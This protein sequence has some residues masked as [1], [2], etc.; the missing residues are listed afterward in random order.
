LN[1]AIESDV[2]I[3]AKSISKI[4]KSLLPVICFRDG[5]PPLP[6]ASTNALQGLELGRFFNGSF[7]RAQDSEIAQQCYPMQKNITLRLTN[8]QI[9]PGAWY[10]GLFNGIGATRTQGKMIVRS[11]A[12]SFSA[13]ISVEGCKTATMW[14]PFCN[15]TIYPLSCSRFDNQTASVI[16]CADSFPSSCLTGAETKTYALDVDGIAEQL[17]IMASNVKVDSNE[18]YLMCYARFEAFAS[19]TLHDYA[20]DIHKVPLIVNKPKAGRWYIVISLSGRENRFAQGTNSS[21]RVCFS[22]NVKVLGCPVGKAGPNCGQ[23]IYILQ[24]VMRRGWLTPFQSYYFPVNDASLSGSSTNFPLE[25]IV[26]NFSSIPELDTSTWTYFLMNIPQG[27]SGGHI[28]FRL[29]SDSTIQ[30]EVYLR[31]GGLP[32]IDD[33]DYYY[34]NR[35]SASRSMFFSLYNSSKEM[36]DFYILYAR[37]G[38]W[39]FGLRQLIDSNTPAASRGSPTLV[40]LSLERC[41][42]GC[43]SY[44]QCRYAFDANGLTSYRFFIYL[45]SAKICKHDGKYI[46]LRSNSC[47]VFQLLFL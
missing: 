6:D 46:I 5:S 38:T 7:E 27:G 13:N 45:E 34:V 12:F 20:A 26:S 44:G 1:V 4:S 40:S 33:R 17:V 8:E 28:H 9:S 24:A 2:D 35:T 47:V 32:T 11:S 39:S 23:Q 30:Y 18:S 21:S 16:S 41:P 37:E 36:V 10:V 22:I 25:P 15:Q 14:G 19:E 42:R 3:T 29:L 31:F 43:S